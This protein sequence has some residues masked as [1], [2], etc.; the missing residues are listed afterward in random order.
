MESLTLTCPIRGLL[1][2]SAKGKDG[3]KPSEEYFRV[4][5]IKH[6][7]ALGYP[8][9]NI[10]IEAIVK[11]LGNAGRNSM[12]ADLAV[13]DVP[14][15]NIKSGDVESLLEH[16][17]ILVEIKREEN[18]AEYVK[19]TQVKPLLDFARREDAL[20]VYWDNVDQRLFWHE[21]TRGIRSTKEG[22]LALLPRYGNRLHIKP[23]TFSDL[24][25]ADNL[26]DIFSRIENM[27]HAASIDLDRRYSVLLQ[28]ILAKLYDEHRHQAT[29]TQALS[30]QDYRSL[31]GNSRAAEVE[32]S[33]V[34]KKAVGFYGR[35]LP[36]PVD[37]TLPEK[38]TG[39]LLMNI[40]TVFAPICLI[41]SKRDVVQQF[42]MKFSKDLYKW[43][44]A[45][46]FTPPT[47]TDY[48]VDILNP[49][50]GEHIKDPACGSADFLTAA[51]HKR[52]DIDPKYSDCVWGVDNSQNAV[53]VAVLNMLL[54]GDGKS[55]IKEGDSLDQVNQE[56]S[57]YDIMV[58]NPPFGLRIV[59]T[60]QGVLRNFDLGHEW[61][62]DKATG[63]W[64]KT[65]KILSRQEAGLLFA[66]VCL[67]QVKPGGR[68]GIIM[69]NGYLGNRSHKYQVFREW[70]LRNAKIAAV[71]AFNRFTFKTSGADVSASVLYMERRQAPLPKADR[72]SSYRF[73]VQMIENVGWNLG[74]KKAAPRYLRNQDDGSFLID[75]F[76]KRILDAD[77]QDSL[78]DLRASPA[79]A[80]FP[81]LAAGQVSRTNMP[82]WSVAISKVLADKDLTMDPKRLCRKF[83]SLQMEIRKKPHFLLGDVVN[84]IAE[85]ID[86]KGK[87]IKKK[88]NQ[89]YN[90]VEIQNIG[91]GDYRSEELRGWELP[92]RAKHFAEEGDIFVGSIWASVQKWCLIPQGVSGAIVTSGCHRL[93]MKTG[94]EAKIY[95]LAGFL[96]SEAYAAQ[97][98]GLARGSDGLAEITVDDAA[99]VLVPILSDIER[100]E[101]RPYVDALIKG[102]PDLRAKINQMINAGETNLPLTGKRSSH[103]ALV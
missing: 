61:D 57:R 37:D 80:D 26:M 98:R 16:S 23:I 86:S 1:H 66:E 63:T 43:D 103:V 54:N 53:Q 102:Q 96:C 7:I 11:K 18:K 74:D 56:L 87:K 2:S 36:K 40:C 69:P 32:F 50:F 58:C 71:C 99:S 25:P 3:L 68:I 29:P 47:V 31:G 100:E 62:L 27:L 51:F 77:F 55:N 38:V 92:Q 35:Y 73:S 48:I 49:G 90:Y 19:N 83:L 17:L 59:E 70:L 13:L 10:K 95:D 82:G 76:G 24:K 97:M 46:F 8:K 72:D 84:F 91:Q 41:A 5:A 81:W 20:A 64:T 88:Q 60:R 22:L 39:E 14:S 12:R 15:G 85:T 93:R 52:R 79:A 33:D 75:P 45:Q 21:R 101:L 78:D 65:E 6:L 42:Y 9:S 94:E 34:L 4:E 67:K 30:I 89:L 44:L 28:L